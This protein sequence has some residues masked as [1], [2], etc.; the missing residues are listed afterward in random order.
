MRRLA[1]WL[2]VFPFAGCTTYPISS[3]GPVCNVQAAPNQTIASGGS[4]TVLTFQSQTCAGFTVISQGIVAATAG[5]LQVEAQVVVPQ[6]T[7][8]GPFELILTQNSH[9]I[10]TA[11]FSDAPFIPTVIAIS[12]IATAAAG[13]TFRVQVVQGTGLPLSLFTS[14]SYSTYNYLAAYY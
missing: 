8:A 13:D 4:G 2:L 10:G 9:Q 14:G 6:D 12:Q 3:P 7:L 11:N 5:K 1:C